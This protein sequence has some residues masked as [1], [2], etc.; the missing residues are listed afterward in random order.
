PVVAVC[1]FAGLRISEVLGLRWRDIDLRNGTLIV[2]GQLGPDGTRV[3]VKSSAS[4][5]SMELLPALTRELREHRARQAERNMRRARADALVFTTAR[6]KPQSRRNA[7]RA[8]Q[9]AGDA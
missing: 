8:L 3:P 6:G 4:A 1:T 7:L 2:S 9:K 5:A